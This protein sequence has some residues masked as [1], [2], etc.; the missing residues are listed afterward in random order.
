M[1]QLEEVAARHIVLLTEG[2][3]NLDLTTQTYTRVAR[4]AFPLDDPETVPFLTTLSG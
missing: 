1:P 4:P 3:A 2:C